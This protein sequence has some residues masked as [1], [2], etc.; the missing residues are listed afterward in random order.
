MKSEKIAKDSPLSD[1]RLLTSK[2]SSTNKLNMDSSKSVGAMEEFV[3]DQLG[4]LKLEKAAELSRSL[5]EQQELGKVISVE[6]ISAEKAKYVGE[7]VVKFKVS[8]PNM[9]LPSIRRGELVGVLEEHDDYE[10]GDSK[11]ILEGIVS[12]VGYNQYDVHVKMTKEVF[13]DTRNWELVKDP[14]L[15]QYDDMER[16]LKRIL[17]KKSNLRDVLFGIKTPCQREDAIIPVFYNAKLDKSQKQAVISALNQN[18]LSVV[19][20]PPGTGKTTT[21]AE[22]V[23]QVHY[24]HFEFNFIKSFS[25]CQEGR[26]G[27]SGCC[28]QCGCG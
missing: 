4:L 13:M 12:R 18:E 11:A 8:N 6:V 25:E 23:M 15:D 16:A 19:H 28:Q 7:T 3:K 26:E 2:M 24:F 1:I 20:G 17:E 14:K 27:P 9:R 10:D 22:I 21:L 5:H